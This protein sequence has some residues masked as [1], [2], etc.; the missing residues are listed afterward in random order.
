MVSDMLQ[1]TLLEEEG[2]LFDVHGR[3]DFAVAG[4]QLMSPIEKWIAGFNQSL[5]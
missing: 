2:V 4:Y 3:V 1:R 5:Y